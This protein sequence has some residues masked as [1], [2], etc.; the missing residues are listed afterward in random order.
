VK[1]FRGTLIAGLLL[2]LAVAA[3]LLARPDLLAPEDTG[4]VRIFTFEKHEV[5]R[6]EVERPGADRIVLVEVDGQ[7]VIE[8]TDF[9]AGRSMVNRVKH[10]LHDLTARAT[11]VEDPDLPELYGLGANAIRVALRLRDGRDITFLVGD[12]NPTAVSY[13]IQPL[14][15]EV[16]YTVKKAAVDYYSLTLDA[17]RESRFASF[18][19]KDV[20]GFTARLAIDG[21]PALLDLERTGD[22]QWELRAPSAMAA[23]E[24]RVRQI[25]GR[26]S[27]LKAAGYEALPAEGRDARLAALGLDAPRADITVRFSSRDP[28]RLRVGNDAPSASKYEELAYMMLDGDDTV[29]LARRGLL[30]EFK[31]DPAL[32][33]NRRVVRMK[34]ADVVAVDATLAPRAGEDLS[35]AHGVRYAAEQWVWKDGV[36]V[37]GSTPERLARSFAELEVDAFVDDAG[38][39]L[40]RFGLAPPV[41]RA[42][43]TDRAGLERVVLIGGSGPPAAAPTSDGESR[44]R[45]YASIEGDPGVYLVDERTLGVVDDLIREGNRKADRDAETA[46]RQGRIPSAPAEV[47]P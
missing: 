20:T 4:P 43:L 16:I 12:P 31:E 3:I 11:V 9:V 1:A 6:V 14:P 22:E 15:G 36:P 47:A 5:T 13:Y 41:V 45:R 21:A 34:A 19:S 37:S 30:D 2:L 38:G 26:V 33:R 17:F 25:I 8:G 18:D 44:P 42:V 29:Y 10:Q 28:L 39:D 32:L 35:G 23:H 24:D 40:S 7:W 46:A 27:A